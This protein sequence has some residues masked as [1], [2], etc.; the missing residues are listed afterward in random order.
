MLDAQE[1]VNQLRAS[2]RLIRLAH[3]KEDKCDGRVLSVVVD[4]ANSI[5]VALHECGDSRE[6]FVGAGA[7]LKFAIHPEAE[8]RIIGEP[9]YAHPTMVGGRKFGKSS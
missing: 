8:P 3:Y 7:F 1:Y 2:D 5:A 9:A 4:Q 6:T